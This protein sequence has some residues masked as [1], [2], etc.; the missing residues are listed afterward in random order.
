MNNEIRILQSNKKVREVTFDYSGTSGSDG[1]YNRGNF[2]GYYNNSN[3]TTNKRSWAVGNKRY[4][5]KN[6]L[7][8]VVSVV[9]DRKRAHFGLVTSLGGVLGN[10]G[11]TSTQFINWAAELVSATDYY[12]FGSQI[13]GRSFSSDSYRYGF[14]GQENDDEIKGEGNS[15]NYKYRMHDPRLGRFFSVDPLASKYPHNSPYAF[16][17]NRVIDGVE[18]E[19]RE[20]SNSTWVDDNGTTHI[21]LTVKVSP[22]NN[23]TMSPEQFS[24]HLSGVADQF[25]TSLKVNDSKNNIQYHGEIVYDASGT[26]N[27]NVENEFMGGIPAGSYLG[28]VINGVN[29]RTIANPE[30]HAKTQGEMQV[31]A[32][33]EI[34]HTGGV[35]HPWDNDNAALDTKLDVIPDENGLPTNDLKSTSTTVKPNILFNTMMY[36]MKNVDGTNVGKAT[37]GVENSTVVSPGQLNVVNDNVKKGNVNGEANY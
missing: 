13:P 4:E 36:P 24:A 8:N 31:D 1:T 18:L 17:E 3:T 22:V 33:H 9:T 5:L 16:S 19:G 21:K 29:Q 6:H 20:W 37:G 27:Y 10:P 7:G 26:I 35:R 11:S 34:L 30:L 2:R 32:V 15:V 23:S 25:K 28:A 12:P 14:Q